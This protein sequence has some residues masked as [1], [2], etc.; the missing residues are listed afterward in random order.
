MIYIDRLYF[1]FFIQE[2]GVVK[3]YLFYFK[4]IIIDYVNNKYGSDNDKNVY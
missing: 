4:N 1:F 3:L 2:V